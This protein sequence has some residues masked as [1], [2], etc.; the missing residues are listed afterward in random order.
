M[1]DLTTAEVILRVV[2][3]ALL[4]AVVGIERESAGQD[5]GFRTHLLLA[6][7]AALFGVASVGAFDSFIGDPNSTNVR[8]DVTRIASYVAAGIGFLGGGAILKHAGTV[9][10]ITTASS[11]WAAAAIGMSAGLGFWAGAIA[12]TIIAL[13][14][15]AGLK[16]VSDW[17]GRRNRMPR[18]MTIV[19]SQF[20]SSAEVMT[21]LR[22]Y[23]LDLIKS[24]QIG[25][26]ETEK[27]GEVTEVAVQ[28]W[29]DPSDSVIDEITRELESEIGEG[30][31]SIS[32]AR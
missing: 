2:V 32:I 13:I 9:R 10:G 19:I 17:V 11:I 20:A 1:A 27:E 23:S 7:G 30:L 3:G 16:P 8:V 22:R 31:Q 6:L 21:V 5:A 29:K 4:G 28:F 14:A 26:S 15:L 25:R 24:I 18:T 12:A